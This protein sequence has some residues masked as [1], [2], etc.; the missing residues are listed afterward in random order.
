MV[1][2][3]LAGPCIS[4]VGVAIPS[5]LCGEWV[6]VHECSLLL[7]VVVVWLG[8]TCFTQQCASLQESNKNCAMKFFSGA[9][10]VEWGGVE[11]SF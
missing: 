11:W 4:D 7:F 9:W 10:G 6:A 5:V 3:G 2:D 8:V 1:D